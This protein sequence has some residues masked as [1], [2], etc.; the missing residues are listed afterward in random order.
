M[1]NPKS[2]FPNPKQKMSPNKRILIFNVNWLGDVLFSTAVIRNIRY[3]FPDSFI[4]CIVPRWCLPVLEGN[5]HLNEI[6]IFDEKERHKGLGGKLR[7]IRLLRSKKF[8]KVFLLH[9][10]F[11]RALITW[12]VGI[13]ERIGY[14]TWKRSFLLTQE[15]R[16][17]S[18]DSLHRIDYYLNIASG[19]GLIVRDRFTEFFV[20]KT[21]EGAVEKFLAK[22]AVD[23]EDFL[24]GINPGGN[25]G[26][27][28]WPPANF[29]TLAGALVK[30]FSAKVIIT[31][32]PQD[33]GLAREIEKGTG[34][35]LIRACG[36]LDL[37]QFGALCKRLDLFISGDT[38]PLHIADACGTK[39][40]IALFGPTSL[41]ITGPGNSKDAVIL[42]K[43][44]GCEIPCYTVGCRDN[45]CMQAVTPDEVIEKIRA[46]IAIFKSQTNPNTQ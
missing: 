29:A 30:D 26:P 21:E 13:P 14:S 44:T 23:K 34:Y 6:I 18:P 9:R 4:A 38:G 24:V 19:A 27:K 28:R 39:K 46:Q 2:Q 1:V 20:G 10:S 37:R 12:L 45:R 16:P 33:M 15:I 17:V 36:E 31:G 40:I 11:S 32:G 22:G 43:E 8:D 3:N 25:W 7:F 41:K 35:K 5:P 42:Q